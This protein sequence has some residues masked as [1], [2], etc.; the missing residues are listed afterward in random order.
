MYTERNAILEQCI[1]SE[2]TSQT[3]DAASVTAAGTLTVDTQEGTRDRLTG[4]RAPN[5][6]STE[7]TLIR[8]RAHT[9]KLESPST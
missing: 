5:A 7:S 8:V 1:E 9:G 6:A 4:V 2:T 3:D